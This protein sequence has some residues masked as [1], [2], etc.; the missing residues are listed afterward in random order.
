MKYAMLIELI[1]NTMQLDIFYIMNIFA[2][3]SIL[4]LQTCESGT[5][6]E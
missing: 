4:V 2:Q 3:K 1:K 6:E 5:R